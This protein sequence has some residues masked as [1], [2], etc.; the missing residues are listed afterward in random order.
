MGDVDL[1]GGCVM[2]KQYDILFLSE[3]AIGNTLE[4]MYAIEYC[5]KV[6][7]KAAIYYEK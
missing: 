2:K 5:L 1:F 7:A 3:L 4:M 6:G